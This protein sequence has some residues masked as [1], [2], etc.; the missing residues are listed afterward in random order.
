MPIQCSHLTKSFGDKTVLKD[1]SFTFLD[2]RVT[3][4]MGASGVGKTTLIQL[5]LGLEKADSGNISGLSNKRISVVFQEDR[6]FPQLTVLENAEVSG[7]KGDYWL[8]RLGLSE[9]KNNFPSTLSGGMKRRVS[10]AR[11]LCDDGDIFILDEPFKGLD[12][13]TKQMVMDIFK[14]FKS[15]K[16]I[17]FVTHDFLETQYLADQTVQMKD[18]GSYEV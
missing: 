11:A 14:E 8:H 9:E 17:L 3:A 13:E 16:T 6:L 2:N 18:D 15:R 10:I 12:A 4:I 1:W 7:G 5:I